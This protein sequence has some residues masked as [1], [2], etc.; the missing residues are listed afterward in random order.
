MLEFL[1]SDSIVIYWPWTIKK[2]VGT[3]GQP[4]NQYRF[5]TANLFL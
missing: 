3:Y 2:D 5:V 1:F 4:W